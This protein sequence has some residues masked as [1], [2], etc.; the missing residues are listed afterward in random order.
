MPRTA[1][2]KLRNA[3]LE[4]A[5]RDDAKK[6]AVRLYKAELEKPPKERR[7]ARDIGSQFGI[8]ASTVT[9][10]SKPGAQTISDFNSSKN[11]MGGES[12]A[13]LAHWLTEMADQIIKVTRDPEFKEVTDKWIDRFLASPHC[14]NLANHWSSPLTKDRARAVNPTTVKNW[15]DMV[16]SRV[17]QAG[18]PASHQF[19]MD[20]TGFME[21]QSHKVR[22]IGRHG[23]HN[24][25]KQNGGSRKSVTSMVTICA[26]GYALIPT[27]IFKGVK[28]L[29]RWG[30]VNPLKAK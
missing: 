22:V 30:S 7:S 20:K 19:A 17:V 11:V 24:T 23:A 9:R 29:K 28:L 18:I 15:F 1:R 10:L 4:R 6:E 27:I 2:S 14:P 12:R 8:H 21:G 26:G 25:Y 13:V 3:G 5:E 16:E